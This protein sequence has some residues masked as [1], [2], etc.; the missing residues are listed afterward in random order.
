MGGAIAGVAEE[1]TAY[2]HRS[3]MVDFLAVTSWTD[4]AEDESR[5]EAGRLLWKRVSELGGRGVYVNNLGSEG[6]ARVREAYGSAKYER[7]SKIK[8]RFDPEN[9][10]HHNSNIQPA[11]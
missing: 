3:A 8:A 2:A 1:A 7:L 9:V 10:F 5:L 6:Q 4:P 11:T